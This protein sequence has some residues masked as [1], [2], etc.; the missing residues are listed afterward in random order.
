MTENEQLLVKL[1]EVCGKL[2]TFAIRLDTLERD[3]KEHK[4]PFNIW[5]VLGVLAAL[6]VL[7]WSVFAYSVGNMITPL[8]YDITKIEAETALLRR[9]TLSSLETV[10]RETTIQIDTAV[11]PVKDK[12]NRTDEGI[13]SLRRDNTLALDN[14]TIKYNSDFAGHKDRIAQEMRW[15]FDGVKIRHDAFLWS[16][17]KIW[18]KLFGIPYPE[19]PSVKPPVTQ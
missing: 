19:P 4:K 5:Q 18:S 3:N 2:D 13:L 7:F 10:R 17:D 8:K 12:Q 11:G 1:T 9:D 14:F 6:S 15:L 16:L